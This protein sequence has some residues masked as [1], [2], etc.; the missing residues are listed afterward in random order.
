VLALTTMLTL[1][2]RAVI[3]TDVAINEK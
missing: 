2:G 3:T 1:T